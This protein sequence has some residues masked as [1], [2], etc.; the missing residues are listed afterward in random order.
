MMVIEIHILL[1]LEARRLRWHL[2]GWEIL[3]MM[4]ARIRGRILLKMG[5]MM[6][7]TLKTGSLDQENRP[8]LKL[9][10]TEKP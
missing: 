9:D 8:A 7:P 6:Q 5:R 10:E 1:N 3:L 2:V 4:M